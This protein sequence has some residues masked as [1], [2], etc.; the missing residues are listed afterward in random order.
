MFVWQ[1]LESL[2]VIPALFER[3]TLEAMALGLVFLS[4]FQ[5]KAGNHLP[6]AMPHLSFQK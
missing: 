4:L 2:W 5:A 1:S 3:N 6:Q